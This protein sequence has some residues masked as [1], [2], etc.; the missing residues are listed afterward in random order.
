METQ[1]KFDPTLR[2]RIDALLRLEMA[3]EPVT[4]DAS[5]QLTTSQYS[6]RGDA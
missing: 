6:I 4:F 5:L 2:F 1:A 3:A